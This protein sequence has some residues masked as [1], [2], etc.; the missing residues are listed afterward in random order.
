[1]R[2]YIEEEDSEHPFLLLLEYRNGYIINGIVHPFRP[3]PWYIEE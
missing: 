1:M 3:L 2:A